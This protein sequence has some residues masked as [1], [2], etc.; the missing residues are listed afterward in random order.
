MTIIIILFLVIS[1][2]C[3][4]ALPQQD[5][6]WKVKVGDTNTYTVDKI[7]DDD[8]LDGDGDKNTETSSMIDEDGES[9]EV[10]V[11]KGSTVKVTITELNDVPTVKFTWN[12]DVTTSEVTDPPF[13][14]VF[15]TVDNKT[16]WETLADGNDTMSVEGDLVIREIEFV[17]SD[18]TMTTIYKTNW[19]T[20][21]VTY[22]LLGAANATHTV[23]EVIYIVKDAGVPGFEITPIVLGIFVITLLVYKRRK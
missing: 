8:D 21:W 19:K 5:L 18:L 14:T 7:F 16:Y 17:V 2:S 9:V 6:E 11:K 15:K 13:P 22:L 12:G 20:G 23:V 1:L 10:V 4:T 3:S